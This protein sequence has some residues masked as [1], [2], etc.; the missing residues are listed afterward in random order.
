MW[1]A[2]LKCFFKGRAA[3]SLA[4]SVALVMLGALNAKTGAYAVYYNAPMRKLPIYSVEREDKKISISFD[5][6]W[7]AEKTQGLLDCMADYGVQCTFFM[8]S[9][10]AEKYPET[11]KQIVDSGHEIGTHSAT[12]SYMSKMTVEEIESELSSSCR[13]IENISGSKVNLFRPPYGDY[14]DR[15]IETCEKGG[16]YV[17]QWDV[18]SLDWKDVTADAIAKRIIE[19]TRAGSIILCH[20]NAEH[21]LEALPHVFAN[22]MGRGYSFVK[23]SELIY[24]E[25]YTVDHEGRQRQMKD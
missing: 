21:T 24:K 14:N 5:C 15:L 23:I 12:H 22:L 16:F 1:K 11:V 4:L 10:W 6:A 8:T 19:R 17:I 9:F 20:N 18:D 7:G 25:G 3:T 2:R 13:A